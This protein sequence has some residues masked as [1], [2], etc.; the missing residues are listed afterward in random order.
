[1]ARL[2][3]WTFDKAL[4]GDVI[5]EQNIHVLDVMNWYLQSHPLKASGGCGG[6]R[7]R[8]DVGDCWDHFMVNYTYPNDVLVDFDSR[9][10]GHGYIDLCVRLF[11]SLGTV[12]S[13]YGGQVRIR[14]QKAGWRGGDTSDIYKQGAVNNIKD[15]EAGIRQGE[16][17]NNS[18]ESAQSTMTCILGRMAA[19]RGT[20][21]TWEEMLAE[22]ERLD[23]H[24]NL[25]ED[26]PEWQ[27]PA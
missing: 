9:Q 24:L 4:S 21:A 15:F 18:L 26:G 6:R 27:P 12:D 22:N 5:V 20:D 19:Y 25:P 10:F 11:G 2:R 14:G 3:N 17:A 23:A 7:V 8:T 13:H 1:M 16:Y